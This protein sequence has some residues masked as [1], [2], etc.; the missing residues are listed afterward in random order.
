MRLGDL[1]EVLTGSGIVGVEV[2][3][4]GFGEF[5]ELSTRMVLSASLLRDAVKIERTS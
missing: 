4:V 2:W 1:D 3:V 5:V